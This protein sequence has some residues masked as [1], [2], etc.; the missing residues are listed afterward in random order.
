MSL[1]YNPCFALISKQLN[2]FLKLRKNRNSLL[3]IEL[4]LVPKMAKNGLEAV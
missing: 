2:L 1:I 4:M 3:S